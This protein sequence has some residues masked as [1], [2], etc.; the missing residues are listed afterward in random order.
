M[1]R[2]IWEG[3][4]DVAHRIGEIRARV[5][6]GLLYL[7][8]V[9]PVALLRRLGADPLTRRDAHCST[10]WVPRP[11]RAAGLDDARRQ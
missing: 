7:V 9:G 11:G 3:W 5:I 2:T 1:L 8:V 4:K 6:V 10:C